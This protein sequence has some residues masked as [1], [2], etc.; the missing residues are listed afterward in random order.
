MTTPRRPSD[1]LKDAD[2]PIVGPN[3]LIKHG[4]YVLV[5]GLGTWWTDLPQGIQRVWYGPEGWILWV[6]F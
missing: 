2:K 6:S 5:G 3:N 4:K 1:V